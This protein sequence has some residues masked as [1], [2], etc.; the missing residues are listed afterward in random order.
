MVVIHEQPLYDHLPK[1][2]LAVMR[3]VN[4]NYLHFTGREVK[5][6]SKLVVVCFK[7]RELFGYISEVIFICVK[8]SE[9]VCVCVCVCVSECVCACMC[10][11]EVQQRR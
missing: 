10:V 1:S 6:Q 8:V 7:P 11:S 5:T 9:S 3:V 2:C 4:L